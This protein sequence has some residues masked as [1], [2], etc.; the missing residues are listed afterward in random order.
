[1]AAPRI[2]VTGASGA[3]G[4]RVARA[5]ADAGLEQRLVV[6]SASRAPRLPGA[7]V[8]EATYGDRE[9]TLRALDGLDVVLMVSAAEDE[10]RLQQHLSFVEAAVEAGVRHLVYTSFVGAS[11][12]AVFTL[13]RDHGHT[14]A[15][16]ERSVPAW[17]FLRDNLYADF[18]PMLADEAGVIRGPAGEGRLAAVARDDVAAAAVA[19]LRDPGQHERKAYALTGPEALTLA[20][21]AAV[22]TEVLGRPFSFHDETL[23]EAYASRA[24]FGAPQWQLDAW[25]STYTAIRSGEMAAVSDDVERLTGRPATSLRD[26]LP[27]LPPR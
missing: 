3:I 9:A 22:M 10:R 5:L 19:V 8:V 18:M 14:E 6:R 21:T 23:E 26:L 12:D 17:T 4:G 11:P 24:V 27:R 13:G 20:E 15:A 1:M 7:E 16:I 25:V 2:G